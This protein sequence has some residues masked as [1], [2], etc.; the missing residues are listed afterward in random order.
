MTLRGTLDLRPWLEGEALQV[1][2]GAMDRIERIQPVPDPGDSLP[3]AELSCFRRALENPGSWEGV[4]RAT[5][6]LLRARRN[7][8]QAGKLQATLGALAYLL[9]DR[10]AWAPVLRRQIHRDL[11]RPVAEA[12]REAYGTEGIQLFADGLESSPSTWTPTLADYFD[13]GEEMM[14]AGLTAVVVELPDPGEVLAWPLPM[15]P[16]GSIWF[17]RMA[18]VLEIDATGIVQPLHLS[19]L[20]S[21]SKVTHLQAPATLHVEGC[22]SYGAEGAPAVFDFFP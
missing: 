19:H 4:A 10:P 15:A 9:E 13:R 11:I 14:M 20:A 17:T 1:W 6:Q 2:S 21:L 3:W 12:L 16:V 7:L 22:P 18:S 8:D 5:T